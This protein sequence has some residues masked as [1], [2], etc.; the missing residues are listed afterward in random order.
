MAQVYGCA[1]LDG[2]RECRELRLAKVAL[3]KTIA[4]LVAK[5]V[6]V[7]TETRYE[8]RY[9]K[10]STGIDGINRVFFPSLKRSLHWWPVIPTILLH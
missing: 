10:I 3:D 1:S 2:I 6:L 7:C 5:G 9:T 8:F 4:G